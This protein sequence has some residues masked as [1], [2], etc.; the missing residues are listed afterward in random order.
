MAL[1][2]LS[3]I[4][5]SETSVVSISKHIPLLDESIDENAKEDQPQ[6]L[7][8]RSRGASTRTPD[9]PDTYAFD[10]ST[11]KLAEEVRDAMSQEDQKGDWLQSVVLDDLP[12]PQ[13]R[14]VR[15]GR[16]HDVSFN[17][18]ALDPELA[19]LLS[20]NR[21]TA[22]GAALAAKSTPS[23]GRSKEDIRLDVSS[24]DHSNRPPESPSTSET[25]SSTR[26]SREYGS[27]QHSPL[28][29]R[30][31]LAASTPSRSPSTS[32]VPRFIHPWR[33]TKSPRADSVERS[34][35]DS[36]SIGTRRPPPSPKSVDDHGFTQQHNTGE[37]YPRK[38]ISSRLG[39][40]THT[41]TLHHPPSSRPT[42]R[43]LTYSTAPRDP[44]SISPSSR[45]SSS[46][47]TA[48]SR[49]Q[50][51]PR[52]SMDSEDRSSFDHDRASP[53]RPRSMSESRAS[54]G[55]PTTTYRTASATVVRTES[56]H[57]PGPRTA[58][59]FRAAGLI[60]TNDDDRF[61]RSPER[62]FRQMAPSRSGYS[63]ISRSSS[64]WGRTRTGTISETASARGGT[65][66]SASTSTAPTTA[67]ASSLHHENEIQALREKHRMESDV[68]L[69]AL[70]DSQ[71]VNKVLREEMAGL[72]DR[73]QNLEDRNLDLLDQLRHPPPPSIPIPI[74]RYP[75]YDRIPRH[76]STEALY[77][78]SRPPRLQPIFPASETAEKQNM[79][80][81]S[82]SSLRDRD[83][84]SLDPNSFLDGS[85]GKR[86]MRNRLSVSSSVFRGPPSTMSMLNDDEDDEELPQASAALSNESPPPSPTL[87]FRKMGDA[88]HEPSHSMSSSFSNASPTTAN[89]TSQD[90]PTSLRLLSDHEDHL[91]DMASLDLRGD[92]DDFDDFDDM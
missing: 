19:T 37:S 71:L 68:L 22:P 41:S 23:A 3:T 16:V 21:L 6:L 10:L 61:R 70:S 36:S 53:Y 87:V 47:G 60:P 90:S 69:S 43:H 85:I 20:P 52:P 17:L 81:H 38:S 79:F 55:P 84:N 39:T 73:I 50:Y 66:F 89:F 57:G 9:S 46:L 64:S 13:D 27:R 63:E 30:T 14:P 4:I 35:G 77:K 86:S 40:P 92:F 49:R 78:R 45:A 31:S 88:A 2:D 91:G 29:S 32:A 11:S 72:R 33:S 80:R 83:G 58:R 8:P 48:A 62:D 74:S 82:S 67:S 15:Q 18:S 26:P 42:L 51:G 76:E 54:P 5:E 75:S 28:Q 24:S 65:P 44:D 34:P 25:W 56:A 1:G 12:I 7:S 59:L